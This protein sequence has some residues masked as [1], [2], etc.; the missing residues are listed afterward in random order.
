[1]D[2]SL[3]RS[4]GDQAVA[5]ALTCLGSWSSM[6]TDLQPDG[7]IRIVV[8][9]EAWR[10]MRLGLRAVHAVD[11][12]LRLSRAERK[13]QLLVMH[14]PSD[15][16]S[17]GAAGS[18]EV[19]IAKDLLALCSTRILLGQSTRVADE[20]ATE[21]ALS[22]QELDVTNSWAMERRGRAPVEDREQPRVQGA[23]RAVRDR[24]AH[25]RHQRRSCG[26]TPA[27]PGE[28]RVGRGP[29]LLAAA[30][31]AALLA[32]GSAALVALVAAG[33][34]WAARWP[35]AAPATVAPA[36][37]RSRSGRAP[38]APSRPRTRRRSPRWPSG[39][40][41]RAGPR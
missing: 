5:V 9:D 36:A 23:D 6:S 15:L 11:S 38:G 10:Q 34:R 2:L 19:A 33:Q 8:R 14:K 28:R 17:V 7:E 21:L 35:V 32:L 20:L 25:L 26:P 16:L 4:R 41:C 30:G 12:D 13:I 29:V 24:A 39:G 22:P 31:C 27:Q 1:M 37:A 40:A 3:L 18:Q